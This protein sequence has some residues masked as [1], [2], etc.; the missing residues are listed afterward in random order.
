[1]STREENILNLEI[2]IANLLVLRARRPVSVSL[3]SNG[4]KKTRYNKAG[5]STIKIINKLNE[6]GY[7]KLN[8]GYRTEKE[9]RNSRIS[10]NDKLLDIFP[11]YPGDVIYEPVEVVELRDDNKNLKNY[12][13]TA[14]TR[15]TREILTLVNK[16]NLSAIIKHKQYRLNPALVAIFKRKFTLYGRLHTRGFEHYQGLSSDERGEITI[17]GDSVVE[18][19]YSGLHPNLLYAKE[20]I[21][22][23]DDPYN[24]VDKR[25]EAR[26]FLKNI[27]LRMIN[28]EDE[29]TA[30]KAANHWLKDEH[31]QREKLKEIGIT[32]ARPL[33][34]KFRKA[35]KKIDHYFCNGNDT[36]LRIMNLDSRIALDVVHHF[37]KKNI[38]ILAIHDSFIVQEKYKEELRQVMEVTYEK[39]TKGYKCKIK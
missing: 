30:E 22:L 24:L 14:K 35:H 28:A 21:Q 20:G 1:M 33:I 38:P 39:H 26:T 8:K 7:I 11:K 9:S 32:R 23:E 25:P 18:L 5:V 15:K 34:D 12:E 16:V 13:D 27:L 31:R 6:H 29:S 17:N 36:G 10:P 3:N 19:D 4:W 37:A 2:L